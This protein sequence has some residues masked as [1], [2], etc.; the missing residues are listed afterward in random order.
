M[1][2]NTTFTIEYWWNIVKFFVGSFR[3]LRTCKYPKLCLRK[4]CCS[5]SCE[6]EKKSHTKGSIVQHTSRNRTAL[7]AAHSQ[8]WTPS[9][10]PRDTDVGKQKLPL[11]R[12]FLGL[13]PFRC[14][15]PILQIL[16]PIKNLLI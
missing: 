16:N 9:N 4:N 13:S 10:L 2:G 6:A 1:S 8:I 12:K 3:H 15:F 11:R 14:S 5:Y 7:S